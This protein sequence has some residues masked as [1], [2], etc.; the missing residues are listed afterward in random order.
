LDTNVFVGGGFKRASASAKILDAV[1]RGEVRMMW[2]DAT[3]REIEMIVRKIPPLRSF[4]VESFF[5][6]ADRYTKPTQPEQFTF[7]PDP[8]DRKFAALS[9]AVNAVLISSDE[10]LLAHRKNDVNVLT[11]GEFWKQHQR[12][13]QTN[14]RRGP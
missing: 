4:R 8:D 9:N 2:N 1:R 12:R 11:P 10:H 3:R 7:I 13:A 5:R 6:A 14:S